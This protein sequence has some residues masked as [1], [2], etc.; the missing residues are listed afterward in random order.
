MP[1]LEELQAGQ[2]LNGVIPG[3][4]VEVVSVQ[5]HGSGAAQLVEGRV[6]SLAERG[7]NHS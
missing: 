6:L 5:M 4:G 1:L 3:A 7:D 2:R